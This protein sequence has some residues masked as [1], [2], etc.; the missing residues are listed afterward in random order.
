MTR[1][2]SCSRLCSPSP[3]P[4][5]DCSLSVFLLQKVPART[6]V[7]DGGVPRSPE[8]PGQLHCHRGWR[9]WREG[10]HRLQSAGKDAKAIAPD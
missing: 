1:G 2:R 6:S 9:S 7:G 5:H 10:T 3:Q 8:R 4:S